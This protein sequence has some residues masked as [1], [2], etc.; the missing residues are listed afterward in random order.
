MAGN[1]LARAVSPGGTW[2]Y[3]LYQRSKGTW[4]I[5]ALDTRRAEAICID[6]PRRPTTSWRYGAT[7]GISR[8]GTYLLLRPF[9]SHRLAVV[10]ST[11]TFGVTL[12]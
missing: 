7:L 9:P 12:V 11:R 10:V 2:V 5:H 8:D 4:F 3:T 1:P 6:L